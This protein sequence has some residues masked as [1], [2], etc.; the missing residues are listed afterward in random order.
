LAEVRKVLMWKDCKD[1]SRDGL[2]KRLV[3]TPAAAAYVSI[4]QRT[5][6]GCGNKRSAS[7]RRDSFASLHSRRDTTVATSLMIQ[8]VDDVFVLDLGE[9]ING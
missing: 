5:P 9:D 1:V 3:G 6:C 4:R 7:V 8:N 2:E